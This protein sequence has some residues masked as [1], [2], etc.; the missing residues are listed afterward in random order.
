MC[1]WNQENAKKMTEYGRGS[2][3]EKKNDRWISIMIYLYLVLPTLIFFIGW[4][5]WY[6]AFVLGILVSFACIRG[7]SQSMFDRNLV[8]QSHVERKVMLK[9]FVLI[10]LWVYLS[11]IGGYCYQNKDH[12]IRS[13]IFRA[14]VEYDWPVISAD[15]SRGLIYYI[16]FWLPSACVGKLFGLEAGYAAQ[17][18]WAVVG[19]Y[20]AYYL[21]CVYRQKADLLPVAFLVFFS[22]LDYVGT[23][24]LREKGMDIN[25]SLHLEWWAVD[26]QFTSMTAQLFWVFNQAIPAWV[27]TGLVL[28]QKN[29]KNI[30][31]ILSLLMLSSTIPFVGLIPVAIY[32]YVRR[33]ME[34]RKRLTE[35]LTFQNLTGVLA[36]GVGIFLYLAG[37]VYGGMFLPNPYAVQNMSGNL[38][39][40][41]SAFLN[42]ASH[43]AGTIVMET[44]AVVREPAAQCLKYMLFFFLE[45]G[46]YLYFICQYRKK[47]PLLYLIV[48]ILL[49]CPFIQVGNNGDFCMRAS[50]PSLFILMLLCM[51]T[52]EKIRLDGK[53]YLFAGYCIV[54]LLGAITP[55]NEINRG[56]RTTFWKV[57]NGESV[58]YPEVPVEDVLTKK[59]FSGEIEGNLF[60]KYLGK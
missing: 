7:F 43:A 42:L 36:V 28:V 24:I 38:M 52:F 35:V 1:S 26:I 53:K 46:V 21:I 13:A 23:W 60:Y 47:D 32:L 12:E 5:K 58:R 17:Y 2:H 16:G 3:A 27:A 25:L 57:E 20:I 54:L 44:E 29:C 41:K 10:A 59:N 40:G 48:G 6:W 51:E 33:V 22:G 55:F 49:I 50:V 8:I 56:V 15:G 11:G 18:I 31:F 9:A 30:L 19:I 14:L 4:M 45:F 34:N 39:I 37:N